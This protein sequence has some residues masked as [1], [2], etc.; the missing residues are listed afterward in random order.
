MSRKVLLGGVVLVAA[1]LAVYW[2]EQPF[3]HAG[4]DGLLSYDLLAISGRDPLSTDSDHGHQTSEPLVVEGQQGKLWRGW[5]SN[6]TPWYEHTWLN[7]KQ[8]GRDLQWND[9]GQLIEE[10]HWKDGY[11]HGPYRRWYASGQLAEEANYHHAR[12]HGTLTG[13]FRN[14]QKSIAVE[15][16][17]GERE[18]LFVAWHANGS[19]HCQV[20]FHKDRPEGRW[21]KWDEDGKL[22]Q[23]VDY[24]AGAIIGT[25]LAAKS[26]PFVYPGELGAADFAF[27]LAQGSVLE[28]YNTL[29]VS[30]AGRCQYRYSVLETEVSGTGDIYNTSVWREATFQ[31]TDEMQRQLRDALKAAD[32]FALNDDYVNRRIMDG[33][34]WVVRL[35]AGGKEKRIYCSNAFPGRLRPLSRTLREQIMVPHRMEL[36]TATRVSGGGAIPNEEQ[37]LEEPGK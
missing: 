18:G 7:G 12:L 13:W 17:H 22:V 20:T 25:S 10:K 19:R 32:L 37:W 35:R 27:I 6:G 23:W 8:H 11:L 33:T 26:V 34:Q 31:L 9:R 29:R 14:G 4:G 30:A 15:Y 28:G 1:G 24:R 36:L 21:Q 5:Y 16:S 2:L 3:E